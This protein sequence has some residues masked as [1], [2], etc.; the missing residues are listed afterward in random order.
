[1]LYIFKCDTSVCIML[2]EILKVLQRLQTPPLMLYHR[3]MRE[4]VLTLTAYISLQ[5]GPTVP[6]SVIY[7]SRI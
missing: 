5:V 4:T 3:I 7:Q 6:T 1:M 2:A